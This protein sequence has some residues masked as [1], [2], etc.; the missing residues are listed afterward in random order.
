MST[1]PVAFSP[2]VKNTSRS[3]GSPQDQPPFDQQRETTKKTGVGLE[4]QT[5]QTGVATHR[6]TVTESLLLDSDFST[7]FPL[8]SQ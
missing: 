3:A 5:N 7:G 2:A 4:Y 8:N 1:V 6:R